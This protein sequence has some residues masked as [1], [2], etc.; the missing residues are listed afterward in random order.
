MTINGTNV[1]VRQSPII[2][3]LQPNPDAKPELLD[4]II[5]IGYLAWPTN[6][7]VNSG[8]FSQTKWRLHDMYNPGNYMEFREGDVKGI[9]QLDDTWTAA[10][11]ALTGAQTAQ[12]TAQAADNAASATDKPRT[13]AAL[14]RAN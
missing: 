12:A 14:Q 13:Q 9:L 10:N 8:D 6:D 2:A 4:D 11:D 3:T 7:D 5:L 1:N